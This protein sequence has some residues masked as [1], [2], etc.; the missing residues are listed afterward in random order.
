MPADN[1]DWVMKFLTFYLSRLPDHAQIFI[2]DLLDP[3]YIKDFFLYFPDNKLHQLLVD[4]YFSKVLHFQMGE[5]VAHHHEFMYDYTSSEVVSFYGMK[6]ILRFMKDFPKIVPRRLLLI[7]ESDGGILKDDRISKIDELEV[8]IDGSDIDPDY[9]DYIISFPNL[10]R[11]HIMDEFIGEGMLDSRKFTKHPKLQDVA[12][13][14]FEADF[15]DI[16]LPKSL[17]KLGVTS[18]SFDISDV[19]IPKSV[20]HICMSK[21]SIDD[22]AELATILPKSLSSLCLCDNELEGIVLD[23][24]PAG[25]RSLDLASNEVSI[26][27]D[28]SNKT[29]PIDLCELN[30]SGSTIDDLFLE[31]LDSSIGWPKKLTKLDVS[32]SQINQ[33]GKLQLPESLEILNISSNPL[34][35]D[36]IKET[37]FR[38]PGNLTVLDMTECGISNLNC[39]KLPQ[40]LKKLRLG[41]NGIDDILSYDDWSEL[42]HLHTLD[43]SQ[44]KIISLNN[45]KSPP[46]LIK[47]VLSN[48]EISELSSYCDWKALVNLRTLDLASNKITS[49]DNWLKPPNLV[50]LDLSRNPSDELSLKFP[51]FKEKIDA[52]YRSFTL[53]SIKD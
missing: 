15:S 5:I 51:M 50:R 42:I 8:I 32:C 45:W 24:L 53:A 49:L 41:N 52:P 13:I 20:S 16:K 38:F 27:L 12:I 19:K 26:E 7:G 48:N 34:S 1:N 43:L 35:W 30:V 6:N 47:L 29:W 33:I 17:R 28:N 22:F 14:S 2:F 11:L 9:F 44:N 18:C 23:D 3:E 10:T 39:L 40:S 31:Q 46:K 21:C 36:C 4:H 37:P 25:L